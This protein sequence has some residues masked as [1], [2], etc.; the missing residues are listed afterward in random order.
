MEENLCKKTPTKNLTEIR[1]SFFKNLKQ[2]FSP[3]LVFDL[4][5]IWNSLL[6]SAAFLLRWWHNRVGSTSGIFSLFFSPFI[7]RFFRNANLQDAISPFLSNYV[8]VI[9]IYLLQKVVKIGINGTSPSRWGTMTECVHLI[10]HLE[11]WA[12]A[13]FWTCAEDLPR[14]SQLVTPGGES[15]MAGCENSHITPSYA[16]GYRNRHALTTVA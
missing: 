11:T 10:L 3:A 2:T 1:P 13:F 9:P 6:V 16:I 15:K 4:T 14:L 8:K 7:N 5:H 12:W